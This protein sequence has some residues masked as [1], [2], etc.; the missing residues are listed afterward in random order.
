MNIYMISNRGSVK[1]VNPDHIQFFENK[2]WRLLPTKD[3]TEDGTPKQYYYPNF[4]EDLVGKMDKA[5]EPRTSD[6]I[7]KFL[8]VQLV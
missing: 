5:S 2:R 3:L 8:E 1:Q 7:D 4:D 6:E